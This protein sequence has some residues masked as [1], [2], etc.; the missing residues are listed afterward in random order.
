MYLHICRQLSLYAGS[1]HTCNIA[2]K[3]IE[4][5]KNGSLMLLQSAGCR[6]GYARTISAPVVFCTHARE[7]AH[8]PQS[9]GL[10]LCRAQ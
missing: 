10:R 7:H 5:M 1:P 2:A 4:C 6:A 8:P 9:L 3:P